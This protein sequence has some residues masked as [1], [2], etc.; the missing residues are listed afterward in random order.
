MF[1][2]GAL[3]TNFLR[4]EYRAARLAELAREQGRHIGDRV[5]AWLRVRGAW[6]P[7]RA[8]REHSATILPLPRMRWSCGETL[9]PP[10][11]N[12]HDFSVIELMGHDAVITR[13]PAARPRAGRPGFAQAGRTGLPRT[14]P[15]R[16]RAGYFIGSPHWDNNYG[17]SH[18]E[19]TRLRSEL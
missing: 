5:L 15:V 18:E 14:W 3:S 16:H 7:G 9:E 19:P 17:S 8:D 1:L 11:V 13:A 2:D 6:R 4:I 10:S 12:R